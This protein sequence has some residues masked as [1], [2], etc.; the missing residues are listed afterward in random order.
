MSVG[1]ALDLLGVALEVGGEER[2][3][4]RAV[5][6]IGDRQQ[7]DHHEGPLALTHVAEQIL[8]VAVG[9]AHEVEDVVLDLERG[10]ERKPNCVSGSRSAW[11]HD[12][13]NAPTR[14][15][16]IVGVRARLAQHHVE[17]V[18]RREPVDRIAPPPELDRLALHGALHRVLELRRQP[19]RHPGAESVDVVEHRTQGQ[20]RRAR[21][22]RSARSGSRA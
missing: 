19:A 1:D 4:E 11:P 5:G 22:P 12:P 18:D 13:S 10:A 9:V 17:V 21:R 6:G 16:R 7:V 2:G 3:H 20:G 14:T 15:G 8:A